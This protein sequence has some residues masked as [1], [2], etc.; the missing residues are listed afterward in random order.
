VLLLALELSNSDMNHSKRGSASPSKFNP[1]ITARFI[2]VNEIIRWNDNRLAHHLDQPMD[3]SALLILGAVIA[4][5]LAKTD[6]YD[7]NFRG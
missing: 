5:A 3:A 1:F 7:M 2:Y 6:K 4:R